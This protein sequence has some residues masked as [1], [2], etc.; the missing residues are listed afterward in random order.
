MTKGRNYRGL[1]LELSKRPGKWAIV[2][3]R[4]YESRSAAP[5]FV[6]P[7]HAAASRAG[8][9]AASR[10]ADGMIRIYAQWPEGKVCKVSPYTPAWEGQID[11]RG[12]PSLDTPKNGAIEIVKA[13]RA[14]PDRWAVVW[15][16]EMELDKEGNPSRNRATHAVDLL[17]KQ[18]ATAVVRTFATEGVVRVYAKYELPKGS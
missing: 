7:W 11:W 6:N 3:S 8:F 2:D 10:V 1:A 5:T 12:A 13:L 17:K 4:K 18:G 15:E 16:E 14:K 9:K